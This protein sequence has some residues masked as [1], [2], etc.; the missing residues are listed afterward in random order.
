MEMFSTEDRQL[1]YNQSVHKALWAGD[2][3][4]M[5][6]LLYNKPGDVEVQDGIY[7]EV[8]GN[9]SASVY[10]KSSCGDA[11]T[12]L[13]H[14]A[15]SMR[16]TQMVMLMLEFGIDPH[17]KDKF[18]MTALGVGL[19]FMREHCW[20]IPRK[21]AAPYDDILFEMH[22]IIKLLIDAVPDVNACDVD[23]FSPSFLHYAIDA[24]NPHVVHLLLDANVAV[25]TVHLFEILYKAEFFSQDGVIPALDACEHI[26]AEVIPQVDICDFSFRNKPKQ[27]PLDFVARTN[28]PVSFVKIIIHASLIQNPHLSR[29]TIVNAQNPKGNTPL[30]TAC[31]GS[32]Q[33]GNLHIVVELLKNGANPFIQNATSRVFGPLTVISVID[34]AVNEQE[35]LTEEE[36]VE[37]FD[38]KKW[39]FAKVL[40]L[41]FRKI[42]KILHVK[43]KYELEAEVRRVFDNDAVPFP[44]EYP[45]LWKSNMYSMQRHSINQQVRALMA[46]G[47]SADLVRVVLTREQQLPKEFDGYAGLDL[48]AIIQVCVHEC[49]SHQDIASKQDAIAK[50]L[51]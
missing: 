15:V 25:S 10:V 40:K 7:G 11:A 4:D 9:R 37:Y 20:R 39:A 31:S 35:T 22:L 34:N 16:C 19:R 49:I 29:T 50:L 41:F 27:S 28:L 51:S 32:G 36:E 24:V 18:Q 44:V 42:D 30:Q 43:R 13:L 47:L 38:E 33:W 45:G 2:V 26:L 8:D 23:K 48:D 1:I 12:H 3:S 5:K 17:V 14:I 21:G 6:Q 46:R